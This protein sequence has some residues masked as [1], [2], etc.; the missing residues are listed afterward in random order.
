MTEP[1]MPNIERM[2]VARIEKLEEAARAPEGGERV[3]V[4]AQ[5]LL[6]SVRVIEEGKHII[7]ELDGGRL[8]TLAA[9]AGCNLG[10]QERT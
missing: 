2:V 10:A 1:H 3:R 7:A 6:G 9:P 8:L 4:E 5:E